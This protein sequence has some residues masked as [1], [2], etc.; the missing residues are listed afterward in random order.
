VFGSQSAL[1]TG[2]FSKA[3]FGFVLPK[4]ILGLAT[5]EGGLRIEKIE[6]N[7]VQSIVQYLPSWIAL[8]KESKSGAGI[9]T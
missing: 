5:P 8:F 2:R 7:P 3:Y 9:L 6:N 4:W 1:F